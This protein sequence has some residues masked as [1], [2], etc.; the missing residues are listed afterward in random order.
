MRSKQPQ[1]SDLMNQTL[2]SEKAV[3]IRKRRIPHAIASSNSGGKPKLYLIDHSLTNIGGHHFDSARLLLQAAIELGL[4][5]VLA[6]NRR[7]RDRE[8]LPANLTILPLFQ[9]TVYS[10]SSATAGSA[11]LPSD[12]LE[13][14]PVRQNVNWWSR[15]SENWTL[16]WQRQ[17]A[18]SFAAACRAVFCQVP[19]APGDQVFIPTLSEFDLVGLSEFLRTDGNA[20]PCEWHLQ[21]HYPFLKGPAASFGAQSARQLAMRAHFSSIASRAGQTQWHFYAPTNGL[22][23]QY[24]DLGVVPFRLLEHPVDSTSD[25]PGGNEPSSQNDVAAP[26]RVLCAGGLR[27][28][29]GSSQLRELLHDLERDNFASGTIQLWVQAKRP[30]K[31]KRFAG[32]H[33][34]TTFDPTGPL[35]SNDSRLVHV[36][37]PL[38]TDAY[39]RLLRRAD[40]G[41]LAYDPNVYSVRCSGVLVELLA[42]G[43]PVVVPEN[44]WLA[45]ELESAGDPAPGLIASGPAGFAASLR[46]IAR[47]RCQY[48]QR[49]QSAAP[50]YARRHSSQRV[51]EQ[52]LSRSQVKAAA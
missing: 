50:N 22:V 52:L 16:W 46:E 25:I 24:S 13:T 45:E 28:D 27:A 49:A 21:F 23:E 15:L 18:L 12:P 3:E 26:L 8:G 7:L 31:L 33:S 36:P 34:L 5:P 30:A 40:V 32:N 29:K 47:Q 20:T 44:T 1:A 11:D 2:I 37:H 10:R 43:V 35:P 9:H 48:W 6:A 4:E 51:I 38:P 19:P 14:L 41:L 42:A 17:Q 39:A